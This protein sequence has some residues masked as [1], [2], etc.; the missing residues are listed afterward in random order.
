MRQRTTV[1]RRDYD[2]LQARFDRLMEAYIALKP[3]SAPLRD[4]VEPKP[5]QAPTDDREVVAESHRRLMIDNAYQELT[6]KGVADAEARAE[7]ERW[8]DSLLAPVMGE[9][10]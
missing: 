5:V 2:A 3:A 9:F 10:Q 7:A 8:A 4:P 6:A 1:D